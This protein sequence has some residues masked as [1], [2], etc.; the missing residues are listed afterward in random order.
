[1]TKLTRIT[2]YPI[3]SL[4]GVNVSDCRVLPSGALEHDRRFALIDTDGKFVNAKRFASIQTIRAT[5]DLVNQSV[6]L[7]APQRQSESF[8]LT[9]PDQAIAEWIGDVVGTKCEL[10]EDPSG[11]FPDDTESTG[12]TLVSTQTLRE[13]ATWYPDL[14]ELEVRLRLRTNLEIVAPQPMW[15]DGLLGEEGL[16]GR[17][18]IAAAD[19]NESVEWFATGICRRCAVPARNA[20][21]GE[22]DP[23]F[24]K[25][26][27][28]QREA[29][30]PATSPR[31]AFDHY[32]RV[33][34]NTAVIEGFEGG[35]IRVGDLLHKDSE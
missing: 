18:Q 1:M 31:Q 17:F 22:A 34:I 11:G 25:H 21:T 2:V 20:Q 3:K 27:A 26:F 16:P 7:T 13:V 9:S 6:S 12:P 24:Q 29:T 32:Y 19:G 33:A 23:D 35:T 14:K 28:Q 8:D 4:D 10:M 30:L 15:E 5:F